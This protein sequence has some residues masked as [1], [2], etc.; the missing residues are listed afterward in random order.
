M[1]TA[2]VLQVKLSLRRVSSYLI[3]IPLYIIKQ[4]KI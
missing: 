3:K 4:I 1:Q 2:F